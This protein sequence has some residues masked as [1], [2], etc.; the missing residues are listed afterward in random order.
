MFVAN[1]VQQIHDHTSNKQWHFIENNNNPADDASCDLDSK[2]KNQI[3]RWFN[4]PSFLWDKKQCWL[5]KCE[6][7]KVPVED[8]ELKKLINVK[9]NA[10]SRKFSIN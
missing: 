5:Q 6:I 9:C 4:G 10:D 7:N 3:K 8:L 2:M 1:C